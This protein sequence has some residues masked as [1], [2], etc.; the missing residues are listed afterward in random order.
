MTDR[1]QR[2]A[3]RPP[4]GDIGV[5]ER[6]R[7]LARRRMALIIL[8][9]LVPITLVAAIV[10]G[11]FALLVVNLVADLLV[12]FYVAMLLQIKQTQGVRPPAARGR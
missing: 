1:R 8:V 2:V 5:S 7:V 11:S 4:A 6:E 10:T 12:A 9:V 3:P